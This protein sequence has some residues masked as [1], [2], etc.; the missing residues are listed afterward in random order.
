MEI[1]AANA[2][3]NKFAEASAGNAT[4]S[5]IASVGFGDEG[6]DPITGNAITPNPDHTS[7]YGEFLQKDI[8]ALSVDG[9]TVFI[10]VS[11]VSSEG[12]G[13]NVS[14]VCLYDDEGDP[15]AIGNFTPKGKD[16][17]TLIEIEIIEE[18]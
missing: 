4:L 17:E 12:N 7:A 2:R 9:P 11:L 8:D 5:P 3:R 18:H 10:S 15:I 6:H 13:R 14:S 16:E 1:V